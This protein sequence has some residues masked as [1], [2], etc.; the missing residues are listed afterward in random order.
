[1]LYKS[2]LIGFVGLSA[3]SY[4]LPLGN[5]GRGQ[6]ATADQVEILAARVPVTGEGAEKLGR[7][8]PAIASH[9]PVVAEADEE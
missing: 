1:M 7:G 8:D 2:L 4:A 9:A 5:H 6:L 3:T